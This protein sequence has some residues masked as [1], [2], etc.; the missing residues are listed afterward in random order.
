MPPLALSYLCIFR[1]FSPIFRVSIQFFVAHHSLFS[2]FYLSWSVDGCAK[3]LKRRKSLES[4]NKYWS[5]AR[6][7]PYRHFAYVSC[8]KAASGFLFHVFQS[9]F[10][11][12]A[13]LRHHRS[14]WCRT[15][16][17]K[18]NRV[19]L[20]AR[21]NSSKQFRAQC[22]QWFLDWSPTKSVLSIDLRYTD[23]WLPH[24]S[25]L[26]IALHHFSIGGLAIITVLSCNLKIIKLLRNDQNQW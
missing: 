2:V 1:K 9:V 20:S 7:H 16:W 26:A 21:I 17:N 23:H 12:Q 19:M 8:T 13:A 22:R 10:Y 24:S 3:S 15:A 6:L 18:I 5:V 25:H 14:Q 4:N 11:F